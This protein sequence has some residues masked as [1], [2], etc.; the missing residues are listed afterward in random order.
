MKRSSSDMKNTLP[1]LPGEASSLNVLNGG[2][3][4]QSESQVLRELVSRSPS[5]IQTPPSNPGLTEV[6]G[7]IFG[8]SGAESLPRLALSS[9]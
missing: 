5:Q 7:R 6:S 4:G 1:D 2:Q 8:S 3:Q 9:Q